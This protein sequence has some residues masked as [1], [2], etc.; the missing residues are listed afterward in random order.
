MPRKTGL[1]S[2]REGQLP[3]DRRQVLFNPLPIGRGILGH[4]QRMFFSVAG[5]LWE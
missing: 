4:V 5:G 3:C 1:D 2:V